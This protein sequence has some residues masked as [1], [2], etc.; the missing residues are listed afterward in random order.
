MKQRTIA[1]NGFGRIG[2]TAL[3][4]A[5]EQPGLTIVAI[6]D[7]ADN[8]ML[9]HLL[10][11]DTAYGAYDKEVTAG[12]DHLVVGGT[13]IHAFAEKD[14]EQLPWGKL[15]VDVVLECT[16]IFREKEEAAAHIRAGAKRVVISAPAKGDDPVSMHVIGVN[17]DAGIDGEVVSNASCTTN[18]ISPVMRV[19]SEAFGVEKSLMTTIHSYTSDQRLQDAP[20][21]DLR[22]A[23][24]A[25]QNIIP[26]STGAAKATAKTLPELEGIFDGMAFRVP[27]ITVSLSDITCLL[28][29]DATVE[30]VNDAFRTAAEDDRYHGV[31]AVTDEE[32]VSSDFIGNPHS[33]I[34]DLP[35]TKV[36]GGNLV[37]V[38]AWYDNEWGY[39][40]RLVELAETLRI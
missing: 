26:T 16:G 36:I 34:I 23:R 1:I 28:K 29:R 13:K 32:L 8:E 7:L 11:H 21:K 9:A 25:A 10:R 30:E 15:G 19:L 12:A 20:H 6:N 24:A 3:K 4:V 33:A 5:L 18:C 2:R 38:I 22:R 40:T 17:A 31:L 35:L 27:T 37:K 14:P 39:A